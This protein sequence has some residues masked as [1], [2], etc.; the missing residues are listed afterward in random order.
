MHI[1]LSDSINHFVAE[2]MRSLLESRAVIYSAPAFA[3]PSPIYLLKILI[4]TNL[5]MDFGSIFKK[6]LSM[7]DWTNKRT[8]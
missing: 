7:R 6:L 3:A 1:F 8:N 5:E 2:L 4:L